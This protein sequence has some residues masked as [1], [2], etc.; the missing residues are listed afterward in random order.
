[1]KEPSVYSM[2]KS[3]VA[4]GGFLVA[5]VSAGATILGSPTCAELYSRKE[6]AA[7][8]L[9]IA[10][11]GAQGREA[12]RFESATQVAEIKTAIREGFSDVKEV[13]Q[14]VK[15]TQ[16]KQDTRIYQLWRKR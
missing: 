15:Q 2:R 10:A 8:H 9:Q 6:A 11:E 13:L 14:E 16:E 1:M 7:A 5:A 3:H 12:I 4:L